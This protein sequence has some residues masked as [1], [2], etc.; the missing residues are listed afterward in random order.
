[1]SGGMSHL[2]TFDPKPRRKD[3]M[4]PV[5]AYQRLYHE[6]ARLMKSEDLKAFDL[7]GEGPF[8]VADKGR[9]VMEV[10]A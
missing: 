7:G 9:P 3:V 2:D 10:F 6:A 4:G 5:E 1:M 8:T